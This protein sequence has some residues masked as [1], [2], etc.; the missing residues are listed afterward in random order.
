MAI[1]DVHIYNPLTVGSKEISNQSTTI[2]L[3]PNPNSGN[4]NLNVSNKLVGKH[5]HVFDVKGGL[6]KQGRI[7]ATNSQ[8]EL[9][10][11]KKGVY[12]MRIE[13]LAKAERIVVL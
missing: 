13:G 5:Y 10:N 6:V 11:A 12:F 1:D 7:D 9:S 3:Y 2:Q 8:L 4:F